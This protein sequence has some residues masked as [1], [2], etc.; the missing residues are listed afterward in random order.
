M[1]RTV[2]PTTLIGLAPC[3]VRVPQL[4][5]DVH[6]LDAIGAIGE[7]LYATGSPKRRV[8]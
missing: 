5:A 4:A 8:R 2:R 6:D 1:R 7:A 3:S